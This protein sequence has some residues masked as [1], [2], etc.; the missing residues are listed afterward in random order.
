MSTE[1]EAMVLKRQRREV[2]PS[3]CYEL[4]DSQADPMSEAQS[5][6]LTIV[7]DAEA[8][9]TTPF[10]GVVF[11][12]RYELT[13]QELQEFCSNMDPTGRTDYGFSSCPPRSS[14]LKRQRREVPPSPSYGLGD[15]QA[16]PM[17]EA[18]STGLTLVEGVEALAR[19]PILGVAFRPRY[20]LTDQELQESRSNTNPTLRTDYGFSSC[21]PRTGYRC[22]RDPAEAALGTD[23]LTAEQRLFRPFVTGLCPQLAGLFT[24]NMACPLQNKFGPDWRAIVD[25][26]WAEP[27]GDEMLSEASV[28]QG[29]GSQPHVASPHL[30]FS[31]LW[32]QSG[33]SANTSLDG[34]Q[35]EFAPDFPDSDSHSAHSSDSE[36][37]GTFYSPDFHLGMGSWNV[38]GVAVTTVWIQALYARWSTKPNLHVLLLVNTRLD[39]AQK[40]LYKDL[41]LA[42][43]GGEFLVYLF[44]GQ[45]SGVK[46]RNNHVGGITMLGRHQRV[47]GWSVSKLHYD[48]SGCGIYLEADMHHTSGRR[49][50][51]G[52]NLPSNGG[53]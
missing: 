23:L 40:D 50:P 32:E 28:E 35:E 31:A 53:G 4:S 26:A 33:S 48:P 10:L 37:S 42:N 49:I 5:T 21:P 3:P 38:D 1:F 39:P 15:S 29:P 45:A 46:G 24:P 25:S 34:Y 51:R 2:S 17:S 9:A 6:G 36:Y 44:P 27:S 8:S 12:P 22:A 16:D 11:R 20:E 41:F 52:G 19:T 47:C 43:L 14:G 7:A 18:Q 30:E 13:V